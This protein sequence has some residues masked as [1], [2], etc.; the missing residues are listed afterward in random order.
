VRDWWGVL[1]EKLRP[2]TFE[3]GGNIIMTQIENEYAIASTGCNKEYLQALADMV[4]EG[5]GKDMQ[6]YTT[7]GGALH[8]LECGGLKGK[9]WACVDFAGGTDPTNPFR[10]QRTYNEGG[11]VGA[12]EVWTGWFDDWGHGHNRRGTERLMFSLDKI[13]SVNGSINFYMFI[14]GTNFGFMNGAGQEGF[15][16]TSYDYDAQLSEI[17]DMTWK[18]HRTL[19]VIKKYRHDVPVYDVKNYTKK[20][21]GTVTFKEGCTLWEALGVLT[22]NHTTYKWPIPMEELNVGYGFALY[23]RKLDQGGV[24]GLGAVRDRANV[25]VDGKHIGVIFGP[26]KQHSVTV[27]AGTLDVLVENHGRQNT[28][29]YSFPKGLVGNVTLDDKILEGWDSIGLDMERIDNLPYTSTLH[30]KVPSFY[31]TTFGVDEVADT[32]LNPKGWVQGVAWVNGFNL[33]KYWTKGPQLTLYVPAGLLHVGENELVVFE[34]ESQSES[35]HTMSF[36][37][38]HQISI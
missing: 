2:L 10:D 23:R 18:Y 25:L 16:T 32:F 9:A 1:F 5:L 14:G 15:V 17:G 28:G 27:P 4:H 13:L 3:N 22:S 34:F 7:D 33:G 26:S 24:L 8:Y 19:E 31:R 37:D 29:H 12:C 6:L 36:D 21:Y 35:V 20:K 38:V 11:P 30:T